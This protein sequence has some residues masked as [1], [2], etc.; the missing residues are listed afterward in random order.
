MKVIAATQILHPQHTLYLPPP[1]IT[2]VFLLWCRTLEWLLHWPHQAVHSP[3]L[4]KQSP[5]FKM[6]RTPKPSP[7]KNRKNLGYSA[8]RNQF[9]WF[10]DEKRIKG[11]Q[12]L[13]KPEGSSCLSDGCRLN[14]ISQNRYDGKCLWQQQHCLLRDRGRHIS[15]NKCQPGHRQ[16]SRTDR[17]TGLQRGSLSQ[18]TTTNKINMKVS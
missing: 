15:V 4:T 18:K 16:N 14:C 3:S 9:Y 12:D 13:Q 1:D 2:S 17:V 10:I 6:R 5:S 11:V 8:M 7:M